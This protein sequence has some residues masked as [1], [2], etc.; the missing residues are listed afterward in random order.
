V[1][2]LQAK[3]VFVDIEEDSYNIDAKLIVKSITDKTK[4]IM[5]VHLY[6]QM[7]DMDVI[8]EIA[9][10]HSLIVVEDAAQ[11][12][13]AEYKGRPAGSFGHY[14]C[15]SFFPSKNLGGSGD[16]GMIVT[17]DEELADKCRLLRTHGER[18][19]Y[20]TRTIGYNS[21]LDTVQAATLLVKLPYLREWSEKRRANAA[22]YDAAFSGLEDVRTPIQ[23]EYS[24]FG[25]YN[26]YT[27]ASP[28][29]STILK[30]L[31]KDEIGHAVYYPVPLHHQEC[32]A[33]LGYDKDE[34]PVSIRASEEVFSI[35]VYTELTNE[36]R[37]EVI[38]AVTRQPA[39]KR[40]NYIKGKFA[41]FI[42]G[43]S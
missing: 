30:T 9:R 35:P 24:N 18:P 29:R 39:K 21:R 20:Y 14:T 3:P 26:Q 32:F 8:M 2:R 13:G 34:F 36:E 16:G 7:A 6:G 31:A 33:D 25:I 22:A 27:L 17:D 40:A 28:A 4:V 43:A 37:S 38:E 23:K 15:F 42:R 12:I 11:A 41:V 1:S 19:K 5:P 10:R